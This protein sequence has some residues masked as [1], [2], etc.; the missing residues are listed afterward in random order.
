MNSKIGFMQGRLS[1]IVG[2]KI[3]SFPWKNWKEEFKIGNKLNFKILEWTLD[4]KK[5]YSNPKRYSGEE[6][7]AGTN[8]PHKTKNILKKI[9]LYRKKMLKM[10]SILGH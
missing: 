9:F 10:K 1:S 3:Q 7:N 6:F 8:I 2:N 4:F 5:L